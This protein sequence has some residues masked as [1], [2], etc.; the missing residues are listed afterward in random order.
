MKPDTSFSTSS[1]LL[2]KIYLY[3]QQI[4]AAFGIFCSVRIRLEW[5]EKNWMCIWTLNVGERVSLKSI[6][7]FTTTNLYWNLIHFTLNPFP[8]SCHTYILSTILSYSSFAY[9]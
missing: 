7:T 3:F 4:L 9:E 1:H 8:T 2:V 5:L 6:S